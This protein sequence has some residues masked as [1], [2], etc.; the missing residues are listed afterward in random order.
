MQSQQNIQCPGN[1]IN[2]P[3]NLIRCPAMAYDSGK[4][5]QYCACP[6]HL[7]KKEMMANTGPKC[8]CLHQRYIITRKISDNAFLGD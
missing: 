2:L 4:W 1:N 3:R 5:F 6:L 7:D 8:C